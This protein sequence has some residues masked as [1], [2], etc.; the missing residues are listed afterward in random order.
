M[1]A[2]LLRPR[3]L[4]YTWLCACWAVHCGAQ[5]A[6][7]AEPFAPAA[8]LFDA[9]ARMASFGGRAGAP[10]SAARMLAA[11]V[12]WFLPHACFRAKAVRDVCSSNG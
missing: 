8:A 11:A 12:A 3:G 7:S 10:Y 6:A 1:D 5:P 2:P 4:R 9:G